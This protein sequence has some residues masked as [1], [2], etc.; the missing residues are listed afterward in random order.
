MNKPDYIQYLQDT[1]DLVSPHLSA[2]VETY[3]AIDRDLYDILLHFT[4]RRI[5]KPLLKPALVRV[6]FELFSERSWQEIVPACAAFEMVNISSYQANSAFDSKLNIL[7]EA[8]KD[9]QFIAAMLSRE[10]AQDAIRELEL[11]APAGRLESLQQCISHANKWIYVAQHFDLNLLTVENLDV[12]AD[13]AYYLQEYTKRCFYGSGVFSGL[14]AFAGGL[15]AGASAG[16]LQA[17]KAFGEAYGLA[18]HVIN[19]IGDYIP[20]TPGGHIRRD[21]QEQFSDLRNGRL[22]LPLYHV[23]THASRSDKAELRTLMDN[24]HING[25]A[26]T[27]IL[28]LLDE[29]QSI[30]FARRF[31]QQHMQVAKGHLGCRGRPFPRAVLGVMTS[32]S[33]SNKYYWAWRRW[34]KGHVPCKGVASH[35]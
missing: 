13:E 4:R 10:L 16:N 32:V 18:L 1:S 17:L 35:V 6:C 12:Y 20:P 2:L 34:I 30:V 7:S 26:M 23:L 31:A 24:A 15:L 21:Y 33:R 29:Y 19:D 8:D 3:R 5:N 14:C 25:V 27:R 11:F 9:S 28:E 22:T